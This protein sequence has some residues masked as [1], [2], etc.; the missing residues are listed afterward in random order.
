MI[1]KASYHQV[2]CESQSAPLGDDFQRAATQVAMEPDGRLQSLHAELVL[3]HSYPPSASP[4]LCAIPIFRKNPLN[5]AKSPYFVFFPFSECGPSMPFGLGFVR[6]PLPEPSGPDLRFFREV[7]VSARNS[8]G[9]FRSVIARSALGLR[10]F[11]AA[12]GGDDGMSSGIRIW[13]GV[14]A[15]RAGSR[16]RRARQ[17][18]PEAEPAGRAQRVNNPSSPR[19]GCA[20]G[21]LRAAFFLKRPRI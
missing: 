5:S 16:A 15:T 11:F 18:P 7:H 21:S 4:G 1:K 8:R 10:Q 14:L 12:L 17:I 19:A 2:N 9:G 20:R 3:S 13:K 6:D